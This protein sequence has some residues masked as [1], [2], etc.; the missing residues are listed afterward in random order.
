MRGKSGILDGTRLLLTFLTELSLRHSLFGKHL[1][2]GLG[3]EERQKLFSEK[4]EVMHLIWA[5]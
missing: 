5:H 3:V 2:M 1:S 4:G